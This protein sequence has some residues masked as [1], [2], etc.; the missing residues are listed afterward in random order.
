MK[1]ETNKM[2][3]KEL[4]QFFKDIRKEQEEIQQIKDLIQQKE[5]NLLPR[6]ITYDK[7]KVQVS[8]DDKFSEICA[9]I[10]DLEIELGQSIMI[11]AKK[12]IQAEQMIRQLE[13]ANERKVMRYYYLTM[14]D[15]QLPTWVQVGIRMNYYAVY[16][17]KL[18]GRA[19][20]NLAKIQQGDYEQATG[21]GR[22]SGKG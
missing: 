14:F 4:K 22:M 6:G 5:L 20:L 7:D 3:V 8:P 19:L 13:D 9:A 17:K 21:H 15:G 2:T 18:H 11:L 1:G 10:S 16:V 12:Q